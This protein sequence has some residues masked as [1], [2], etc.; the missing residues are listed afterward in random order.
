MCIL[1]S[2]PAL[3]PCS[4]LLLSLFLSRS[5]AWFSHFWGHWGQASNICHNTICCT[6]GATWCSASVSKYESLN[7]QTRWFIL[8]CCLSAAGSHVVH[9]PLYKSP[10]TEQRDKHCSIWLGLQS[11]S[12]GEGVTKLFLGVLHTRGQQRSVSDLLGIQA[13]TWSVYWMFTHKHKSDVALCFR[14]LSNQCNWNKWWH[15]E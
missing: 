2:R 9:H 15:D 6:C 4:C 13:G 7:M 11:Q 1:C 12:F 10:V 14:L 5:S 8:R 3:L